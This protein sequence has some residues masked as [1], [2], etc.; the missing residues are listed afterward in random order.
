[1]KKVE[2]AIMQQGYT[3]Y[4]INAGGDIVC[5]SSTEKYWKTGISNPDNPDAAIGIIHAD[6]I[7]VATSGTYQKGNH[8]YDPK[9]NIPATGIKSVTVIGPDIISTDIYATAL[10]AMGCKALQFAQTLGTAYK[11]II[12]DD[13]NYQYSI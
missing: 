1:M 5:K 9:E 7:A 6:S 12:I 4:M 10:Y 13:N 2:D 8:I 11:S 3:T